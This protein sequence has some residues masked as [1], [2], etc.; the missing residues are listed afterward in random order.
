M[1]NPQIEERIIVLDPYIYMD[2]FEVGALTVKIYK[3]ITIS[4]SVVY[5]GYE[6]MHN[7]TLSTLVCFEMKAFLLI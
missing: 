6:Y 1:C 2:S 7:I 4:C 3:L 5:N